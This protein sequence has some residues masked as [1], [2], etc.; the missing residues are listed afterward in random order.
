MTLPYTISLLDS[1]RADRLVNGS[2]AVLPV[3]L[4]S[5]ECDERFYRP[6]VSH[7][8]TYKHRYIRQVS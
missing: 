4:T 8:L 1:T 3:L 6:D 5:D 2:P 7:L